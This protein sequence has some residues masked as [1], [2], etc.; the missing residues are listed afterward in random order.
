MRSSRLFLPALLILN[1][2]FSCAKELPKVESESIKS[3]VFSIEE[4]KSASIDLEFSSKNKKA[5]KSKVS[6]ISLAQSLFFVTL[7]PFYLP[8]SKN[9]GSPGFF[10]NRVFK[11]VNCKTVVF[12]KT[13]IFHHPLNFSPLW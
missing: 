9:R 3:N 11:P 12:I 1:L 13:G 5:V 10:F 2:L 8:L 4:I 6:E 7:L